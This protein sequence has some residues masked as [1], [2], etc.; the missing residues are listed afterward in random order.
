M[1][2]ELFQIFFSRPNRLKN[3]DKYFTKYNFIY[4]TSL[5]HV[6]LNFLF[7]S[8]LA[9][10]YFTVR[11]LVHCF[12]YTFV[13]DTTYFLLLCFVSIKCLPHT[14]ILFHWKCQ[15]YY[16]LLFTNYKRIEYHNIRKPSIFLFSLFSM[17]K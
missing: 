9:S 15:K 2:I 14:H 11:A 3:T 7:S 17:S 1:D 12:F 10:A 5:L 16:L 13:T 8:C 6:L 4:N